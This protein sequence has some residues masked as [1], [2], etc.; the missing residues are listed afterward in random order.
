MKLCDA[1]CEV[2]Q[3]GSATL[4]DSEIAELRPQVPDWTVI[5]VEGVR[6]LN[7]V[8]TFTNF[9]E[10]LAFTNRVGAL[11]EENGHHPAILTEWGKVSVDWWTHKIGGLHRTDFIMAAKMDALFE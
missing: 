3:V 11:A 7:R 10:A 6:H 2:C 9:A 8:F 1:Q 5:D 4:L